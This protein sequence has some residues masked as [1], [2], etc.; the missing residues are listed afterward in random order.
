MSWCF[1]N[2]VVS[3][4]VFCCFLGGFW[5]E[6]CFDLLGC[7]FFRE[8]L[9][10]NKTWKTSLKKLFFTL[11]L[12]HRCSL[13]VITLTLLSTL[14]ESH[15]CL[16]LIPAL[17]KRKELQILQKVFPYQRQSNFWESNF[18]CVTTV[19]WKCTLKSFV[20]WVSFFSF[21]IYFFSFSSRHAV[22]RFP[23]LN[24]PL[25]WKVNLCLLNLVT[26]WLQWFLVIVL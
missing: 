8:R 14:T 6:G 18:T 24:Q 23:Q 3:W 2:L 11:G 5:G 22:P 9:I 16:C 21:K 25:W 15:V 17:R 19:K 1:K 26:F 13:K 7:F 20:P 12:R 4:W 10:F